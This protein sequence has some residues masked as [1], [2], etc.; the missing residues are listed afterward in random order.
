MCIVDNILLDK[1]IKDKHTDTT[2]S[3]NIF[4]SP[5]HGK[6]RKNQYLQYLSFDL[7]QLLLFITKFV[8]KFSTNEIAFFFTVLLL[9]TFP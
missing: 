8:K 7:G 5:I 9:F 1:I 3:I 6:S 4:A 2:G